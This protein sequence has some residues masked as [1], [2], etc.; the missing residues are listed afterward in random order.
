MCWK[1]RENPL[2]HLMDRRIVPTTWFSVRWEPRASSR[3]QNVQLAVPRAT[4]SFKQVDHSYRNIKESAQIKFTWSNSPPVSDWYAAVVAP[5]ALLSAPFAGWRVAGSSFCRSGSQTAPRNT[6]AAPGT[7]ISCTRLAT[8]R[9]I[10][11][12]VHPASWYWGFERK[13]TIINMWKQY[14]GKGL[15]K[16]KLITSCAETSWS[17]FNITISDKMAEASWPAW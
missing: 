4:L 3:M 16:R 2:I 6:P 8:P 7:R 12:L 1:S 9:C 14:C 11:A 5:A 13:K 17:S 10:W 15:F